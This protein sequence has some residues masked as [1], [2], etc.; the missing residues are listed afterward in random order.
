MTDHKPTVS[1]WH[2]VRSLVGRAALAALVALAAAAGRA[3]AAGA[4]LWTDE[5]AEFLKGTHTGTALTADQWLVLA[6]QRNVLLEPSP[7]RF[8]WDLALD[9]HGSLYIATG[10]RGKLLRLRRD[11]ET[12]SDTVDEFYDFTDPVIFSLALDAQDNLYAA[13]SP[14]GVVYKLVPQAEGK[15]LVSIFYDT[16]GQY[17]WDMVV[18][19]RGQL[20]LATGPDGR[21]Y[22]VEPDGTGSVLYDSPDPHVLCL[23]L[24]PEDTV[25]AGTNEHGW[26]YRFSADGSFQVAY[27]A[28][29]GEIHTMVTDG[30]GNL[31]FGTAD[32][33]REAK[34]ADQARAA[35]AVVSELMRGKEGGGRPSLLAPASVKL[36]GEQI[37]ATNAVYRLT[38]V[39][40]ALRLT[41]FKGLLL[42][43]STRAGEAIYL[44]TGNKG[45]LFLVDASGRLSEVEPRK[46]DKIPPPTPRQVT[47]LAAAPVG[48]GRPRL[49]LGTAN[50]GGLLALEPV[51]GSEGR[52]TS[53]VF[54]ARFPARWG[55]LTIQG[56]FS[57]D[58]T[59][60]IR[61][62]SGHTEKPDST[63]DEWSDWQDIAPGSA[64]GDGL[65]MTSPPARFL[66]YEL[67]LGTADPR[68]TPTVSQVR[69]AYLTAN[70]PPRIQALSIGRPPQKGR[71][72]A[73]GTGSS[74]SS[75]EQG[76]GAPS[77]GQQG[78]QPRPKRGIV[79]VYWKVTD[80]DG[81]KLT[82]SLHFRGEGEQRWKLVAEEVSASNYNWQTEAVPDGTY[83]VRL[84]ASDALANPGDRAFSAERISSAFLV[85]NTP[86]RITDLRCERTDD[87]YT[88]TASVADDTSAIG[89]LAYSIDA[90]EWEPVEPTDGIFDERTEEVSVDIGEL[91]PGEHTITLKATD[92]R[93]NT[94]A[95]KEVL[96]VPESGEE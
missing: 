35:Q 56:D 47:A 11:P 61:S 29:E 13:T 52:F 19:S 14:G 48:E 34:P 87:T 7:T 24:G 79:A 90:Q 72:S 77:T 88:L 76:Q 83:Y 82:Y 50:P 80:P 89:S 31:Y 21:I 54:D 26:I 91:E 49:Y 41:R 81:D 27:D 5:G 8:V 18:G 16:D 2:P 3:D 40:E 66:Q 37:Q 12:G 65:T 55:Q 28:T 69:L 59:A 63:W 4:R 64:G 78:R 15:P 9:R 39:G 62:R 20:Y 10:N 23:A 44:G 68:S 57:A 1:H 42:L 17:V 96:I 71:A 53:R 94:A 95:G 6:G 92:S 67:R 73:S 46:E 75:G 36:P 45:R 74:R 30:A 43:S 60:R 51:F 25:Y 93:A 70:Q 58:T 85:D 38:P 32:L 22:C 84:T 86:P 33:G